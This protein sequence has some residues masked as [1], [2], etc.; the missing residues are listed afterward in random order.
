MS[1]GFRMMTDLVAAVLVGGV[2]GYFLD[3]WLGTTPW[4]LLGFLLLGFYAGVRNTMRT[5]QR[6]Q[7]DIT[8]ATGGD[9][10]Q[11]LDGDLADDEND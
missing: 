1:Y 9:I 7:A 6:M 3:R 11:D 2:F 5:Y 8:A 10:G 4:L